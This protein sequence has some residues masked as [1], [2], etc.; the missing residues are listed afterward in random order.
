MNTNRD[1]VV[2]H[3]CYEQRHFL[4]VSGNTS[5][6]SS[7]GLTPGLTVVAAEIM[8]RDFLPLV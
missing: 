2:Q 3:N 8:F 6:N 7:N 1:E 4:Y 5:G